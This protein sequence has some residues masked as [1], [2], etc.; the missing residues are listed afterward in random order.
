MSLRR[1]ILVVAGLLAVTLAG[2]TL[3]LGDRISDEGRGSIVFA[4]IVAAV[5]AVLSHFLMLRSEG[6]PS[7]VF[8]K[9]VLGGMA[10][11]MLFVLAAVVVGLTALALPPL[12]LVVSLLAHFALFLAVEMIAI[13][14]HPGTLVAESR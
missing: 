9:L 4:G 14:S 2:S 3:I 8:V 12:P 11:R 5:N 10:L 7:V 1:N 13:R 6:R